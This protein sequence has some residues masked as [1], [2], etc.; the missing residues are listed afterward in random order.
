MAETRTTTQSDG[1]IR[2]PVLRRMDQAA[3]AGLV[4]AALVGMGVYWVANGGPRDG[5]IEI[6]RAAPLTARYQVDI[7]QAAWPE[8]AELPR[9]GETLAQR[10]VE[11]RMEAGPFV[12]HDDLLRVPGI[13]PRTLEQMKPYL[14]PMPGRGGSGRERAKRARA[15]CKASLLGGD[16]LSPVHSGGD[17]IAGELR[18]VALTEC[19]LCVETRMFDALI[20]CATRKAGYSERWT[21]LRCYCAVIGLPGGN[22]PMS[23]KRVLAMVAVL[24]VVGIFG[25]DAQAAD[26]FWDADGVTPQAGGPGTWDTTNPHFSTTSGGTVDQTWNNANNDSAIFDGALTANSTV[27]LSTPI[28]VQN[29]TFSP[30]AFNYILSGSTIT[31]GTAGPSVIT[32]NTTGTQNSTLT[33]NYTGTGPIIKMGAGRLE[34]NNAS[35]TLSGGYTINQG[36]INIA[37]A[38]RLGTGAANPGTLDPDWFIFNGGGLTSSN[39]ASQDLG[40]TRGITLQAGGAW[41]GASAAGNPVVISAPITGTGNITVANATT[42]GTPLN[43]TFNS[44]G[45][46][47]LSN[48]ANDFVGN[49]NVS[50]GTLRMGAS[51]VIPDGSIV[52]LTLAGVQF[53]MN[54]NTTTETVKSIMGTAGTIAIGG[55]SLT[56]ANPAGE[57]Y[58]SVI[59]STAAGKFIKNGT[60]ALSLS[61]GS[62]GFNG[63]FILNAGTLGVGGNNIFGNASNTSSVTINGGNLSNTATNGRTI[64]APIPVALNADFSADD[65]LFS[66]A[67]P[68]QI[69]FNGPAT[70][71]ADR[72][73]TVNGT[74]NLGFA[75]LRGA[76]GVDLIKAGSGTLAMQGTTPANPNAFTGDVTVQAGRLQVAGASF[77]GNEAN[78]IHLSGGALNASASRTVPLA[79]P[80][81][82]T[83]NSS[84]TTTSAAAGPIFELSSNS[85]GGSAGT[86]TLRND[87]A[88]GPADQL[89]V[90]FSGN[91]FD[92]ARPIV[93]D[94]G[95]VGLTRF[96]S[97]NIGGNHT[98][99]G[100]ISGNGAYNRSASATGT[101]GSTTL[102][103]ANT[104][105]GGTTV[106]DG[107][108]FVNNTTGSGT[109]TGQV[110]V[111]GNGTLAGTGAVGG[112]ITV[113]NFGDLSPG[114][115]IGELRADGGLTFETGSFLDIELD[116]VAGN[117]VAD[118]VI[119]TNGLTTQTGVILDFTNAGAMTAGDYR[120]L[121]YDAFTGNLSDFT[122]ENTPPSGFT[123][124]INQDVTNKF[125]FV[126]L[127]VAAAVLGDFNNDNKVD[128]ADYIIWRENDVANNP[129]PNDNG[130]ATQAQRYDLWRA[131]FGN[132]PASG[133]SANNAGNVPEPT[134]VLLVALGALVVELKARRRRR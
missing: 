1:S 115:S 73:I 38:N 58:T 102:T 94:N 32:V 86:L 88:D 10:I 64:P 103:A 22:F 59:S 118:K 41:F 17:T 51:N 65:S 83:A 35:N 100:V 108:L 126:T 5:L 97:F 77:V 117:D 80:I 24:A 39:A 48:P 127:G 43:T 67:Q 31:F 42:A 91:G 68:G 55:G 112:L 105:S 52:N 95:A 66:S 90:R 114:T 116:T 33:S 9:V 15:I 84:I 69:S 30:S 54:T 119:V 133:S 75:D 13:G 63:E 56:V 110:E 27:T 128:A 11:S 96:S 99:S 61:G 53:D 25:A 49:V 89:D 98:F 19:E 121:D 76:A 131:N 21:G 123:Y 28:T 46:W 101:G 6:D 74:A 130:L 60:G 3:V 12:D 81:N 79:N 92:F 106:N 85:I 132:P 120:F 124:A 72:T 34:L 36:F 4:L 78:I 113:H 16:T 111:N 23:M 57:S 45:V 8:L 26:L 109:G 50:A 70:M 62:T 104:Y 47:I 44:G 82:L 37:A 87:G 40:A 2:R 134:T 71:S 7:N 18:R 93:I 14:L 125:F 107:T 122:V 20:D 129:L 29:L